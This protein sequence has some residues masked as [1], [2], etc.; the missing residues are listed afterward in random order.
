MAR[1]ESSSIMI[2]TIMSVIPVVGGT[3]IYVSSRRKKFSIFS[4]M[5]VSI[6]W[7]SEAALTAW[8]FRCDISRCNGGLKEVQVLTEKRMPIPVKITPAGGY[9]CIPMIIESWTD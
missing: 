9:T 3:S 1:I 7:V 2:F 5:L 8:G 6:F 4:N